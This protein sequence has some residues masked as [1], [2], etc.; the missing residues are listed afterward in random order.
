MNSSTFKSHMGFMSAYFGKE[1]KKEIIS[2]YWNMLKE[3]EDDVFVLA[4]KNICAEF[5]PTSACP[6]PLVSHILKYCGQTGSNRANNAIS[7]LK[8]AL[9][10]G[11]YSS[12]SFDDPALHYVI[13]VNGGWAV[14]C[15]WTGTQWDVNE[16][17]LIEAYKSAVL[18][19][20]SGPDHVAG[21]LERE[22]G[23]FSL[24][25]VADKTKPKEIRCK[26][27][28]P[29]I[30]FNPSGFITRE[31]KNKNINLSIISKGRE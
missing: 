6:F 16:G 5:T 24:Y 1:I 23:W 8:K 14:L 26:E 30:C 28:V 31:L 4:I 18:L 2:L 9:S 20:K 11:P 10:F 3:L 27:E 25:I 22:N 7:L 29:E 21:I 12:V 15:N 13:Q 17:R 19:G